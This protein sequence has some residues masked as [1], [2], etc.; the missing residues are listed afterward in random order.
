MNF[1]VRY[2]EPQ[3]P[4][5]GQIGAVPLY[6]LRS[7][8]PLS[9][10]GAWWIAPALSSYPP[11]LRRLLLR[12]LAEENGRYPAGRLAEQFH[13]L[14]WEME[15][16]S[17]RD[18]IFLTAE[19]LTEN[20]SS[21][22]SLLH[23]VVAYPILSG[24][25]VRHH[26]TRLVEAEIR[27]RANPAYQANAYLQAHLWGKSYSITSIAPIEALMNMDITLLSSYY[28]QFIRRGLR[29]IVLMAP[30]LPESIQKWSAWYAPLQYDMPFPLQMPKVYE[31]RPFSSAK[32]VS[33][34]LAYPWVRPLHDFYVYYRMALM[35]LGGYFGAQL[36]RAIREEAGL[37]YGIYAQSESALAGSYMIISSEV[38][39]ERASEA[40]ALIHAEVEKWAKHPFPTED[41]L[42]EV[43][44]YF[45]L[46]SMP[47]TT[48]EWAY[49]I[50]R[51]I[52][53]GLSPE[54]FIQ[55]TQQV[56]TLS[57]LSDFPSIDLPN[58]P[59]VQVA[60][61]TDANIFALECV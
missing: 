58:H 31:T 61:G 32:Q 20:L 16:E 34:R 17:S 44:N 18:A 23:E 46:H 51:L 21:A 35:R 54:S 6:W 60:V 7:P 19:G 14:G 25:A 49:R 28:E 42:I 12:L 11:G 3:V 36:M 26:L 56:N 10:I 47:E 39:R 45:L 1:L 33:L 4:I 5:V 2:Q 41:I 9:Y 55:Q 15:W 43:R 48:R 53:A 24:P 52:A 8:E 29:G 30:Y 40:V 27:A 22:L 57:E 38:A 59:I 13:R 50:L 37:T